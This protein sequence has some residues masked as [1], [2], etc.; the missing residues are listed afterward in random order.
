MVMLKLFQLLYTA[1]KRQNLHLNLL[2]G[3]DKYLAEDDIFGTSLSGLIPLMAGYT[4]EGKF[5]PRRAHRS[6]L[7]VDHFRKLNV[8]HPSKASDDH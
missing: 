4:D 8:A 7:C 2:I 6:D 3:K 1:T 5:C